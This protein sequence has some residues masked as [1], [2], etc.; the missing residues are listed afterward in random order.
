M[1]FLHILYFEITN[2]ICYEWNKFKGSVPLRP[3][4]KIRKLL[5]QN[6]VHCLV[7]MCSS[8]FSLKN[9]STVMLHFLVHICEYRM[10]KSINPFNTKL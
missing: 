5:N 9:M 10:T 4:K 3:G 1:A 2:F 6:C 8:M 7:S